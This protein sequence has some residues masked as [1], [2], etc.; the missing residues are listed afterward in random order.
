[1][2]LKS[3]EQSSSNY[4]HIGAVIGALIVAIG[5][6]VSSENTVRNAQRQQAI[7]TSLAYE[8]D[9]KAAERRNT[10]RKYLTRPD[11]TLSTAPNVPAYGD[12][13]GR[14]LWDSLDYELN[15]MDFIAVGV[16]SEALDGRMIRESFQTQFFHRYYQSKSYIEHV[17]TSGNERIWKDFCKLCK[18]VAR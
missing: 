4:W 17:Q 5:W 6:I 15:F 13:D 11:L 18:K 2:W 10:I 7:T 16:F 12:A 8:Y 9:V 3:L 1:L 14:E